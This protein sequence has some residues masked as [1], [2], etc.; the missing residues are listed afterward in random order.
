LTRFSTF[1]DVCDE[2]LLALLEFCALAVEFALCLCQGALMLAQTLRWRYC[3]T[4]ERFL[5]SVVAL[6]QKHIDDSEE[7]YDDVHGCW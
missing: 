1:L 2:F 5:R 4:K 3:A 7:T 6:L